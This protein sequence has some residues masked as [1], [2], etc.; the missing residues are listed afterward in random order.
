MDRGDR[1]RAGGCEDL[2]R[3]MNWFLVFLLVT[4]LGVVIKGLL[5]LIEAGEGYG[6]F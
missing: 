3:Q 4:E 6:Y 2:A 5:M 1:V